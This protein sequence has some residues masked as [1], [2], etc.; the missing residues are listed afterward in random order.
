MTISIPPFANVPAP[1][2]P[3]RSPWAQD[4]TRHV[5]N[6]EHYAVAQ[7]GADVTVTAGVG[8]PVPW[9]WTINGDSLDLTGA[10]AAR[11]Q[12]RFAKS[13]TYMVTTN[14]VFVGTN[15]WVQGFLEHLRAAASIQM[16]NSLNGAAGGY[17]SVAPLLVAGVVAGDLLECRVSAATTGTVLAAAASIVAVRRIA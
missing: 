4:V 7:I 12:I 9:T 6:L 10:N 8:S 11:G 2:D 17:G 16:R 15:A 3:I 13:G 5:A 1:N 14:L